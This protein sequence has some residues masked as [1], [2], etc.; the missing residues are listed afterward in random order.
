[1]RTYYKTLQ[2]E[3]PPLTDRIR[4]CREIVCG[5]AYLHSKEVLHNDLSP[6]NILLT[7]TLNVKICDFGGATMIGD[8]LVGGADVRFSRYLPMDPMDPTKGRWVWKEGCGWRAKSH[9]EDDLFSLGCL[10]YEILTGN[11]PYKDFDSDKVWDL[12]KDGVYPA[13]DDVRPQAFAEVI[14]Q[15]WNVEYPSISALQRDLHEISQ[16]Q[17]WE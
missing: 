12:Y 3:I 15:C 6:H 8:L 4:W 7:T 9:V 17:V 14:R 10:F 5:V 13:L 16:T 1:M 2:P 11:M